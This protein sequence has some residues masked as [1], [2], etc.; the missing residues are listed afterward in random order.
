MRDVL[1][2]SLPGLADLQELAEPGVCCL[3]PVTFQS[4]V[5]KQLALVAGVVCPMAEQRFGLGRST[6][7]T[8]ILCHAQIKPIAPTQPVACMVPLPGT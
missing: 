4:L 3:L 6:V 5:K 7:G 8:E 1:V 2:P